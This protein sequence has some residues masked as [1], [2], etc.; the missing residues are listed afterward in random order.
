VC[1]YSN[2]SKAIMRFTTVDVGFS[3]YGKKALY[4]RRQCLRPP[5]NMVENID[6]ESQTSHRH[7]MQ[8]LI[9]RHM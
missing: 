1:G 7:H 5:V 3:L 9:T 2:R 6:L 4:I 8:N